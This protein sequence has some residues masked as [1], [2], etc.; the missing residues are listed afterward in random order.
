[1]LYTS[2]IIYLDIVRTASKLL[3]FLYNPLLV[4]NIATIRVITY[5]DWTKTLTIKYLKENIINNIFIRA[6][7]ISFRD[8]LVSKKSIKG[9][10]F[11]LF[12]GLIK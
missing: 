11:T 3:K 7:N 8:N 5:L 6:S 12:R 2:N 4:Y 1:M 9:Y 10:L